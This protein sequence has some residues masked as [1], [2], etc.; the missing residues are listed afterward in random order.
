[1][2][3]VYREIDVYFENRY[4]KT[5][6]LLNCIG[7][8]LKVVVGK[9]E[10]Q[11]YI[12]VLKYLV[13]YILDYNPTIKP[14]QTIAYYSWILK[15]NSD[16]APFYNLWEAD[17]NGDGYI[18][19]VDY[20]IQVIREQGEECKKHNVTPSF[21]TFAQNIVIS[22]GVY[23]GLAVDAVRYPSPSHM[24]GWWITTDLYDDNIDS[25]MNVHYYHLAFK[26]PDL[27]KYLALP[28]GFRFYI[29]EREKDVWFS[30]DVL[31]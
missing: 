22:K 18:Q 27:L 11:D 14:D 28:Y 4:I 8:E 31:E 29:S 21:P 17:S 16:D 23:E 30:Q 13:D 1:M 25:L 2:R 3:T 6:G 12:E 20:S 26:R 5:N 24:S 15:L 10:G 9:E 7:R 19:G